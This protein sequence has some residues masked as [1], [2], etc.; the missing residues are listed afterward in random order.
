[1]D[2]ID[3]IALAARCADMAPALALLA[4]ALGLYLPVACDAVKIG[5]ALWRCAG[6]TPVAPRSAIAA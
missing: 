4:M 6:K 5:A 3:W 1:M 2:R